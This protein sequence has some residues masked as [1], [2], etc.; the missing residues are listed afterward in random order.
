MAFDRFQGGCG[1]R[2]TAGIGMA[3][4]LAV[5]MGGDPVLAQSGGCRITALTDPPRELLDCP[6]GLR[7]SAEKSA[8]YRL[9]DANRDGS[10]EAVELTAK[11]LLIE[12]APRPRGG[13]QVLTPH[14]IASVRGTTWAVEVKPGGTS[15]FVQAGRVGVTRAGRSGGVVLGA[16]DGVDVDL[17]GGPLRPVRWGRERALH[18]LARFGR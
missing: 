6:N 4:G 16:G 11:G 14:A 1:K 3:L 5:V 8:A 10:P 18:L 7:I 2:H 15:V 13:F 17:S 12:K 9:I